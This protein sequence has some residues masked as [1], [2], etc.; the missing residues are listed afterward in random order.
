MTE[1]ELER[2]IEEVASKFEDSAERQW[3]KPLF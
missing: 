2:K 3:R 1:Q